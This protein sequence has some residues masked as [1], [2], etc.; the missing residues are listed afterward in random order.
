MADLLDWMSRV[1]K[2]ES[3]SPM[4]GSIEDC[5]WRGGNSMDPG[6]IRWSNE[7]GLE[8]PARVRDIVHP[9]PLL[10]L[11]SDQDIRIV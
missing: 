8:S 5:F 4:Q 3:S 10:A 2:E 11:H 9:N 6:L 1:I 7:T